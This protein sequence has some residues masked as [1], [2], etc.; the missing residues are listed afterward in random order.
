MKRHVLSIVVQNHSGVL[1]RISGLFSRRGYNI[2]SLSVGPTEDDGVSRI[3]VVV[4]TDD[5]TLLQIINQVG[6]LVDV[7]KIIELID[8]EAVYRELVMIKVVANK[9]NRAEIL[10]IVNIFRAHIVDVAKETLVIEA[11]GDQ[12]KND[13]L[14]NMLEPHGIKE[15]VRTGLAGIVRGESELKC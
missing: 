1:S 13:A 15:I 8:G 5:E 6:K 14:I 2:D 12:A 7:I 11:I 9:T 4:H 3:T 10:E